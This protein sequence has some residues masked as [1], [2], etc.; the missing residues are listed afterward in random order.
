MADESNGNN[1]RDAGAANFAVGGRN[2]PPAVQVATPLEFYVNLIKQFCTPVVGR[3]GLIAWLEESDDNAYYLV[4]AHVAQDSTRFKT[5]LLPPSTQ[6]TIE[7]NT[8]GHITG[9]AYGQQSLGL[10]IVERHLA[11][12]GAGLKGNRFIIYAEPAAGENK[13]CLTV[14]YANLVSHEH[15]SERRDGN[16][17]RIN[18]R[19]VHLS[20]QSSIRVLPSQDVLHFVRQGA[21]ALEKIPD[22]LRAVSDVRKV[23]NTVDLR[24]VT[25]LET[26]TALRGEDGWSKPNQRKFLEVAIASYLHTASMESKVLAIEADARWLFV[27]RLGINRPFSRPL[28]RNNNPVQKV[29]LST[30]D[31]NAFVALQP[32][33]FDEGYYTQGLTA[34]MEVYVVAEDYQIRKGRNNFVRAHFAGSVQVNHLRRIILARDTLQLNDA[35]GGLAVAAAANQGEGVGNRVVVM[36]E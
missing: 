8:Q 27:R 29:A 18:G 32:M 17:F 26:A 31:A 24:L 10:P 4:V 28:H 12:F 14:P 34:D 2:A 9:V 25:S 11:T 22:I 30:L 1:V 19:V 15:T 35:A 21:L 23:D 5:K 13:V 6:V 3:D 33:T 36:E 20:G 16:T 7:R